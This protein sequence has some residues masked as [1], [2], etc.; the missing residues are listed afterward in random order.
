MGKATLVISFSGGRTS[1]YMTWRL[2]KEWRDR[3][4]K[5]YVVFANTG[6]EHE[7][8]LEFV[9]LCDTV[10]GFNSVWIEANVSPDIGVGTN[11]NI[12][13]HNS[14]SREGTPFEAVIAKYGIPF[15][16]SPHCTRDLKEYPIRSYIRSLG[17]KNGDYD[18]AIGIRSDEKDRV[19]FAGMETKGIIYPLIG[20]DIKKKDVLEWWAKQEF[21]L[22]IPEHLGNCTWCWK[23]SF[24][25]LATVY[26]ENPK[27]FDFPR[28]IESEY[29]RAGS[30][31]TRLDKDI[32]P[33]RGWKGVAYIEELA[34]SDIESYTDEWWEA[35][36]GC[37]GES[38]EVFALDG[39]EEILD[40][41]A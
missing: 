35:Q 19:N 34:S 30:L 29:A 14:A 6:Q 37:G 28:R 7:E 24:K 11:F 38:C 13:N 27:F 25:K 21:D 1:A 20:W 8:T 22:K 3:Y 39:S 33:F 2:L 26:R 5:I 17:L 23:K 10:L 9:N 36:G 18:M 31:A 16:K 32:K 4:E 40:G 12:V 15:S 41:K